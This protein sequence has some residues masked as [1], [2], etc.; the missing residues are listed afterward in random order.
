MCYFPTQ[1]TTYT[2]THRVRGGVVVN[3][4]DCG[5]EGLRI[6]SRWVQLRRVTGRMTGAALTLTPACPIA[7]GVGVPGRT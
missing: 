1:T 7:S 3:T 2:Q 6:E 4:R 5:A